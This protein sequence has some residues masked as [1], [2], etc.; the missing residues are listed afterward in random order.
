[1]SANRGDHGGANALPVL[2][3]V[4]QNNKLPGKCIYFL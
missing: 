1:M 3:S 4:I 2:D